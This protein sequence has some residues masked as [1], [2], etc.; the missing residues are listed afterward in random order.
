MEESLS[1]IIGQIMLKLHKMQ[2]FILKWPPNRMNLITEHTKELAFELFVS[3]VQKK[4]QKQVVW[5]AQWSN[6]AY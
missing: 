2:I 3:Y 4:I 6:S 1:F 5:C